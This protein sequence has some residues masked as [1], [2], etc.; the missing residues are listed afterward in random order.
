MRILAIGAHPDD[1][2]IGANTTI[3]RARFDRTIIKK[4]T[5]IDNLVQIAHNVEIGENN[6]IAAQT[7]ISGSTKTGKNV[8][9]AG[10]VGVAGHLKLYDN[11]MVSAQS[12]VSKNLESGK[13]R[14]TPAIP[15]NEWNRDYVRRKKDSEKI[16]ELE[17]KIDELQAQIKSNSN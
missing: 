3:D 1:V 11:V 8:V 10:Q 13:Y 2:E 6:I 14:G 4:G 5:K 9:L 15:I 12:G 16:I 17:K 7:G